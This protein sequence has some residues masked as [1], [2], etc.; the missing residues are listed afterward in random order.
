MKKDDIKP[1]I[2]RALMNKMV[3]AISRDQSILNSIY[4]EWLSTMVF[5]ALNKYKFE[6]TDRTYTLDDFILALT[7]SGI[8]RSNIIFPTVSR[9][10][11]SYSNIFRVKFQNYVLLFSKA[12]SDAKGA[13]TEGFRL[14]V[15]GIYKSVYCFHIDTEEIV[16]VLHKI[17]ELIPSWKE[18]LWNQA[19][20]EAQ[21]KAKK[22]SMSENTIEVL[23]KS[24]MEGT[25]ISYSTV[26]Q[27]LRVKV[28]FNIGHN[29]M[30][31]MYLSHKNFISQIDNVINSVL[32]IKKMLDETDMTIKIKKLDNTITWNK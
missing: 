8:S 3:G 15:E 19:V 30:V 2:G 14:H 1:K 21:K 17:D 16:A 13:T 18:E 7:N 27:K 31:E 10:Y 22:K 25:D 20:L 5:E 29:I 6:T 23:L 26:K 12:S 9:R 4:Q 24:K 11:S 32:S 28:F